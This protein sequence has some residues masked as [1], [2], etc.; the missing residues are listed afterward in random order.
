MLLNGNIIRNTLATASFS[1]LDLCRSQAYDRQVGARG[2]VD[3]TEPTLYH[4]TIQ[5]RLRSVCR[6]FAN[7]ATAL[8]YASNGFYFT[9]LES[10]IAFL[11][12]LSPRDAA[13]IQNTR[14]HRAE[15][16]PELDF[17]SIFLQSHVVK[18]LHGMFGLRGIWRSGL[19][20]SLH[21][22]T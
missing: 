11:N 7:E 19:R 10:R 2:E 1:F 15:L 21:A 22:Y 17:G 8:V 12:K 18:Q 3:H 16:N 9:S 6:T 14:F 5:Q 20:T 4:K 13:L